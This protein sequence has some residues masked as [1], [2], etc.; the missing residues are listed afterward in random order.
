MQDFTVEGEIFVVPGFAEI[1]GVAGN[2]L[3]A[4]IIFEDGD[5]RFDEEFVEGG[6]KFRLAH[7]DKI[8][9][10]GQAGEALVPR[11]QGSVLGGEFG[12]RHFVVIFFGI[13][14]VFEFA[15]GFGEGGLEEIS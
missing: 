15:G 6:K 14:Q 9:M 3:E 12:R 11:D 13:A 10:E 2:E 4:E 7:N 5:R 1:F 8:G